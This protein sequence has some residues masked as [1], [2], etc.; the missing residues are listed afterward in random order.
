MT[1]TLDKPTQIILTY[2]V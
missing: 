1:N 2:D